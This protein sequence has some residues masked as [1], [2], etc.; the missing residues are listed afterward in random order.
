M[1]PSSIRTR[2]SSHQLNVQVQFLWNWYINIYYINIYIYTIFI[3]LVDF[4]SII[5]FLLLRL[6]FFYLFNPFFL[7]TQPTDGLRARWWIEAIQLISDRAG[8]PSA[9]LP[10]RCC[11]RSIYTCNIRLYNYWWNRKFQFIAITLLYYTPHMPELNLMTNQQESKEQLNQQQLVECDVIK[12]VR[13]ASARDYI[14]SIT[15][16]QESV[17][18]LHD[19]TIPAFMTPYK[20]RLVPCRICSFA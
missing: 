17:N 1:N 5:Y 12:R 20:F 11:R 16:Q 3:Y 7:R 8:P 4:F 6:L 14:H 9:A 19:Y 18:W 2:N 15:N 13:F 10:R